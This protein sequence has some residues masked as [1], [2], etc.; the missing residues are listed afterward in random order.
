MKRI[1]LVDD[2]QPALDALRSRLHRMS[3]KWEV[4]CADSGPLAIEQMQRQPYDV[5]VSDL[6]M[7]GMDGAQLLEIVTG[8]GRKRSASCSPH[9]S[10]RTRRFGSCRSPTST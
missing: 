8:A 3:G 7:P 1:L 4:E 10:N 6:R 9:T 5:I 2:E